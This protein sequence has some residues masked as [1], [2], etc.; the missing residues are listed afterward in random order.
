MKKLL[1]FIVCTMLF[2]S[3][4]YAKKDKE[5]SKK[6]EP[7]V[8][9]EKSIKKILKDWLDVKIVTSDDKDTIKKY[10]R[11]DQQDYLKGKKGKKKK[12]LPPGLQKK[13]AR[14]GDLPP[15]WQ[16]KIAR[17]EVIDAELYK[18]AVHIPD[19]LIKRLPPQP[20][21]TAL[22][23]VKGKIIRVLEATRTILDVFDL[24]EK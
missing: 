15:G 12:V 5:D 24:D 18:H 11:D 23:K 22:I 8:K 17:G 9:E 6:V 16:K 3:S 13:V 21:G 10:Y 14:G 2:L 20:E 4:A 7:Q 19:D 1:I